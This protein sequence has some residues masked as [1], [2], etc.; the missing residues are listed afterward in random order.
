METRS[1][2]KLRNEKQQKEED[3]KPTVQKQLELFDDD[4]G[5][6]EES[7]EETSPEKEKSETHDLLESGGN[8]FGKLLHTL[9]DKNKTEELLNTLVKKD[10]KTGNTYLQIPVEN[11][12]VVEN[13]L[14]MLG[15]LL[16]GFK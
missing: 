7:S 5:A 3:A 16:G 14:K 8:F 1:Y 15:Q 9:S 13:G 11:Q 12:K 6:Y 2:L 4:N 10:E